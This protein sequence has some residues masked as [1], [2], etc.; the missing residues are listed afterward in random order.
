[1]NIIRFGLITRIALLV[2]CVELAAFGTLGWF[3]NDRFSSATDEHLR[4]RLLEVG[5]MIAN[6][7]L[8]V[9]VIARPGLMHQL[10][11]A[12]L[13]SGMAIGGNGRVIVATDP[14]HLGRKA[15]SIPDFD[16]RWVGAAVPSEQF[17]P[18]ADALTAVVQLRGGSEGSRL[19]TLVATVSMAEANAEKQAMAFW[20]IAGSLLFILVSSAAIVLIAQRL[21][22]RRVQLSLGVLK[23]VEDGMLD[24]RIPVSAADE[25][26]Q[27]QL[28]IN[29]MTEKLAA[30]L[31]EQRRNADEL[32]ASS[33]LL[34]SIIEN[35][36]NMIFLKRAA[37]LRFVLFNRAGEQL[38]GSSRRALMGKN[39]YDLF[40]KAQADFFTA[41]D[42][43]VLAAHAVADIPEETID[44]RAGQRILHTKKLALYDSAGEAEFLLGISEDITERKRD[45]EELLRHRDHLEELVNTRT[46][47]LAEAKAAAEA[48]NQAKSTFL[49]NMSH[50]I[51]TPLNAVLG[52]TH[53]LRAQATPAQIER[54]G[55]IDAAGKHLLSIINDILDISKI[56]AGKLQL[57]HRDFALSAV[58]DHVR[59]LLGDAARAKG[60]EIRIDPDAV[61]VWLRGDVMRLR[62]GLLNYASNALKFTERG[63]ITLAVHLLEE[64]DGEL[65]VRFE[66]SDTGIGIG[67][68]KL[69][70]LFQSFTQADTSTTRQY[71]GTGLGLAI[72]RRLAELMGGEAGAESIP[73]Q[74]S[75]F[76]FT[77]RLQ[78]GHGILPQAETT[79]DDAEQRLR[80]RA[81][82]ARLLLAEDNPINREVA[83][84]L[85]HSVGLAVDVAEDG[86]EALER[87]R[88]HR[89]DLVLMD[90]QM[91]NLD[92][93]EATRAIRAL[94]GW[95]D[96]PILAMTANAFDED[97]LASSLAGM[98]DH[99]AKPVDP[100]QLFSTLL[101]WLPEP[102]PKVSNA[103]TALTTSSPPVASPSTNGAEADWL[104]RL[105]TI[106]DLDL[107]TG[108]RRVNGK[109]PSYQRILALFAEGH[110][111]D[112]QQLATLIG[113]ND[114]VA[115]ERI[116]HALRGVAGNVG[117]LPIY[118]LASALDAALKQ[119]DELAVQEA[120]I[121]LAE[122]LQ[123]LIDT[124]QT[125]LVEA[126]RQ[127]VAATAEP[128]PEQARMR[129]QLIDL[130]ESGD[131]RA[132]HML[133]E[134]RA[135]FEA[136]LGSARC[137]AVEQSIQR[138]DYPEAI[139][140]L[141]DRS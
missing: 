68:D 24:A 23:Q 9:G 70:G 74:G 122:R 76:W 53:L 94:S 93:L 96:I 60:L 63:H 127:V 121:P 46:A 69:A 139:R 123:K 138:F 72:T 118:G 137:S 77:A 103:G 50:E 91:P 59:S 82:R 125:A 32:R 55:K 110:G 102:V 92:G 7:E 62:Q 112:V 130:L 113:Q 29:S 114:L 115:A 80:A 41:R 45:A 108:L 5:S 16:P 36:P 117:A 19:Y 15:A 48:A 79:T 86:T 13:L 100:E 40:P 119:G 25:L 31:N 131:S 33:R 54:L 26:G 49:T 10:V 99:I 67:P 104:T 2:V 97:R 107:D 11:G 98:N 39:D 87:A 95:K 84:E 37:D 22:T 65:L 47:Q 30:L 34:D 57:E 38:L 43:E 71:G 42:R 136:I 52:L 111:D 18:R 106:P 64:L 133:A 66:V 27:L 90:I 116:T 105:A 88:Q 12:P 61:P 8:A 28:G 109:L 78:R 83:L 14:S 73:G 120:F 134:Q 21:I 132:R 51:R 129:Q 4:S 124:L 75:T 17:F 3:Y 140:L 126:P 35:I 20:G 58:L 85:L 1:V 81:Q 135:S 44:T 101:K 141:K 89:Y 6:E 128:T 56:E